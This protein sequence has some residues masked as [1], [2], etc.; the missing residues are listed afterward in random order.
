[1]GEDDTIRRSALL[2]LRSVLAL[3][4]GDETPSAAHAAHVLLRDVR[5]VVLAA[6]SNL[7]GRGTQ[8]VGVYALRARTIRCAARDFACR[9]VPT[10]LSVST[11]HA[12]WQEV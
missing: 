12:L 2:R 7:R 5:G 9:A 6:A 10:R 11:L 1:M 3:P 8:D 4:E